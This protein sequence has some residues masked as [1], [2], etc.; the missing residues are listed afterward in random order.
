MGIA[1]GRA[2]ENFSFFYLWIGPFSTPPP[3]LI[4]WVGGLL[5]TGS[6]WVM[7]NLRSRLIFM[8]GSRWDVTRGKKQIYFQLLRRQ[9]RLVAR[10]MVRGYI[11]CFFYEPGCKEAVHFVWHC[12]PV[13]I[14]IDDFNWKQGLLDVALALFKNIFLRSLSVE[15]DHFLLFLMVSRSSSVAQVL[16]VQDKFSAATFPLL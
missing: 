5:G 13:P 12:S 8:A 6:H 11:G 10:A 1:Y 2:F 9:G 7:E 14:V 16:R 3:L 4:S 15:R